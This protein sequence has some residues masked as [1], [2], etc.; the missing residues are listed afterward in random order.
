L[1]LSTPL[2]LMQSEQSGR[3]S[4]LKKQIIL[5]FGSSFTVSLS[6]KS[7]ECGFLSTAPDG[8][9]SNEI[10]NQAVPAE[11]VVD[12]NWSLVRLYHFRL[13]RWDHVRDSIQLLLDEIEND[14]EAFNGEN[15]RSRLQ[16]SRLL[17]VLLVRR[18]GPYWERVGSGL[19]F[20]KDWPSTSKRAK[21]RAF[22]ERTVLN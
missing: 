7:L 4:P 20:A 2:D 18:C 22:Q 3:I 5:D 14:A 9:I 12:C 11:P 1:L 15:F 10:L 21:V 16:R 8:E 6:G 13:R 19:M 17:Y